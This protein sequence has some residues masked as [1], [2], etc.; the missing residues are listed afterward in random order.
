MKIGYLGPEASFTHHAVKGAFS[1]EEHVPYTTIPDCLEGLITAQIDRA[2]VPLENALEGSVPIT[3]DYLYHDAD[4]HITAELVSPIQ[5]HLM[6]HPENESRW[7]DVG[8]ILSHSHAIAQCHKYLYYRF[9]GRALET[10]TSTAAAAKYVSEHPEEN[11]AAIGN[12]L[13]A[14]TYGLKIVEHNIHDYHFNHTRF[15]VLSRNPI[16]DELRLES[17][18]E[19]TTLMVTLPSDD[20]PGNLHQVLSA[21]SWRQ[22]NLSK[23]ES[24]PLKTGLGNYFFIIDVE[25]SFEGVLIKGAIDELEALGCTVKVLGSYKKYSIV[26]K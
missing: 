19:K 9:R 24:R 17:E 26:Q 8:R 20:R 3:V 23:I 22:L 5:Q 1:D 25:Q 21:F 13:A 2:V 11:S 7:E 16:L 18:A 4:V 10:S 14:H 15:V 12:S 6:V